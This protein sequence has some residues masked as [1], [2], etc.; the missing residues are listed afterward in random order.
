MV[1][2]LRLFSYSDCVREGLLRPIPPSKEK[3]E[4]S[5]GAARKWLDE[6]EKDIKAS[7]FNSCVM[8]SYLTIF[9]SARALLFLDGFREKSHYCIGRY[10]DEKYAQKGLLES[11]W[12]D[13]FDHYRGIRH[14]DQYSTSFFATKEEAEQSIAKAKEFLERISKLL[15]NLINKKEINVR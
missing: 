6:A 13:L 4:S 2:I 5:I 3:A 9:H 10:L 14:D 8:S 15:T 12:V 11:I 7:A 1:R